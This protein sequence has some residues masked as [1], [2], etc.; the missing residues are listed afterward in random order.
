MV[1]NVLVP[2]GIDYTHSITEWVGNGL[3]ARHTN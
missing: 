2:D 3:C 1:N